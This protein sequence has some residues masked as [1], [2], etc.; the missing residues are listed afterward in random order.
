MRKA[1]IPILFDSSFIN[2]FHWD[3][4][5][6]RNDNLWVGPY[7]RNG[8]DGKWEVAP[9]F[10]EEK[11]KKLRNVRTFFESS[12][13][14]IWLGTYAGAVRWDP[15]TETSKRYLQEKRL[16]LR[17]FEDQAQNIWAIADGSLSRY[18]PEEDRFVNFSWRDGFR[19]S[20]FPTELWIDQTG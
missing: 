15:E 7:R 17:I 19:M 3:F 6:D 1:C 16:V 4:W 13:G 14:Q 5:V 12:N 18:L 10:S 9:P 8:E 2:R 11:S 20:D